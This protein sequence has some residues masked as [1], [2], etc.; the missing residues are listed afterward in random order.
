MIPERIQM[1]LIETLLSAFGGAGIAL[2]VAAYF[3]RKFLDLQ[4]ARATAKYNAELEQKSAIL[5]TELSIYAHEQN[6]GISRL[7]QQRSDAIRTI[8]GLIT[9]WHE[10]LLEITKPNEPNLPPENQAKRYRDLSKALVKV[11]EELSMAS[12]DNAIFFQQTTFDIIGKFGMEAMDLSCAF[13]DNT[14]GKVDSMKDNNLNELLSLIAHERKLLANKTLES[15]E[16]TQSQLIHE[17]RLL[18]KAER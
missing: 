11:A 1:R 2:A 5:K 16:Q 4:V 15:F 18:M 7:D 8:Y 13:Y 9:K 14:F 3:G 10:I 17:F 6:V 12:W